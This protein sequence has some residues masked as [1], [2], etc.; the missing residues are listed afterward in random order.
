MSL[1]KVQ[2]DYL[3]A[4]H[5]MRDALNRAIEEVGGALAKAKKD[6]PRHR[7]LVDKL[8][9]QLIAAIWS[10]DPAGD[11]GNGHFYELSDLNQ[12]AL[13]ALEDSS[14][15]DYEDDFGAVADALQQLKRTTRAWAKELEKRL[16]R[17][18]EAGK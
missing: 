8:Q 4:V 6:I 3:A 18:G 15:P 11:N 17:I 7:Q 9:E 5:A 12:G 16:L 1:A 2:A 13:T 14:Y 10:E